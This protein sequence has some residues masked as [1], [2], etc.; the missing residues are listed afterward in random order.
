MARIAVTKEY[1]E[2]ARVLDMALEQAQSGKGQVRHASPGEAFQDQ[3]IVQL[4]EWLGSNH[5]QIFQ[6][7][8]KAVES[9]R[10]PREQAIAELLGAVNYLAAAALVLMR[11]HQ[12]SLA[13]SAATTE[14]G[15]AI[16]NSV[17]AIASIVSC[18][19]SGGMI[20]GAWIPYDVARSG[21]ASGAVATHDWTTMKTIV[22]ELRRDN[23]ATTFTAGG[24][25]YREFTSEDLSIRSRAFLFSDGFVVAT[26]RVGSLDDDIDRSRRFA[27]AL[28]SRPEIIKLRETSAK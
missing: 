14:H 28:W 11:Q 13:A 7:C 27:T 17:Q 16:G 3:Q 18:C 8:K 25:L 6:A 5:G 26:A 23:V 12:E 24:T 21:V 15:S 20:G 19:G 2:L 22:Y 10:L 4:G 9:A 1:E